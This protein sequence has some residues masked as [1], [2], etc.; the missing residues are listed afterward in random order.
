MS[1]RADG[2]MP[3]HMIAMSF[4]QDRE[5]AFD[6]AI[7]HDHTEIAEILRHY[8]SQTKG[9]KVSSQLLRAPFYVSI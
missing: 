8:T 3:S 9:T 2:L 5:T 4:L 7:R 1:R 6:W